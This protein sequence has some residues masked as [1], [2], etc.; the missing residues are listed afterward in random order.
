M[1]K[2]I[3]YIAAIF[4]IFTLHISVCAKED[5]LTISASVEP[6]RIKQGEEGTLTIKIT[7]INGIRISSHPKFIIV[8]DPNE[9]LTFSKMF[10]TASELD[11]ETQSANG[12]VF[13]NL[14]KENEIRFKVNES[15]LIGRHNISGEVIFTAVF[16]DNWSLK[17]H[18]RFDISFYSRKNTKIKKR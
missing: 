16:K 17:T 7:P 1:Q 10:F 6:E 8:M 15:A 4:L 14:E 13:L 12:T 5:Y 11:F 9:S 2:K 18:Q 3:F